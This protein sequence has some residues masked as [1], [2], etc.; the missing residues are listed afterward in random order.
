MVCQNRD[1]RQQPQRGRSSSVRREVLIDSGQRSFGGDQG[2]GSGQPAGKGQQGRDD[3]D[4]EEL[5]ARI[6]TAFPWSPPRPPDHRSKTS[7]PRMVRTLPCNLPTPKGHQ[8]DQERQVGKV[9]K[10][11]PDRRQ[12]LD[13]VQEP[14]LQM[15]DER[16]PPEQEQSKGQDPARPADD[17]DGECTPFHGMLFLVC[18]GRRV[19]QVGP[20]STRH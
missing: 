5:Q 14:L 18:I 6:G 7:D 3:R 16:R 13:R 19:S 8:P 15:L 20:R 2:T 10:P 17:A 9:S 11:D 12:L 1:G 4:G